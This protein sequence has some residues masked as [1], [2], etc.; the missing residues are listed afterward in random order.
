VYVLCNSP[1]FSLQQVSLTNVEMTTKFGMQGFTKSDVDLDFV[2]QYY[3]S[4]NLA[5]FFGVQ[6]KLS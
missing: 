1:Q 3:C 2:T 6:L 4:L 5:T